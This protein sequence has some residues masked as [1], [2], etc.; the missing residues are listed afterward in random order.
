MMSKLSPCLT[1]VTA[2]VVGSCT[3]KPEAPPAAPS[4]PAIIGHRGA[5]GHAPENTLAAFR[6]AWDQGA[7][8]IEGDFHLTRD[9]HIVCLHDADTKRTAAGGL[10]MIVRDATLG[11]LRQLD[12][13]LWKG[14]AFRDERIPTLEEVMGVVPAGKRFFLEVKCGPEIV[15]PLL[16]IL[17][18]GPLTRDQVMVISFNE[19]VIERFKSVAPE[20]R[21]SWLLDVEPDGNGAPQPP[22]FALIDAAARMSADAVGLQADES[23][24]AGYFKQLRTAGFE[25]HVWTVNSPGAARRFVAFAVD[26]ITT[27]VPGALRAAMMSG[28]D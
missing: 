21:A 3:P 18:S 16:A 20:W 13:G 2:V 1:G 11:E 23:L 27:D 15:S 17:E 6:L 12:V 8:G 14:E 28:V 22:V 4:L 24:D 9:G 26:S 19:T 10:A 7:D 5:S 25:R